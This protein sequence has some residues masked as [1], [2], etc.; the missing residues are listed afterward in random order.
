VN[1]LVKRIG[2]MAVAGV[3]TEDIR[4]I[5]KSLETLGRA[6][7]TI[8]HVVVIAALM[9]EAAAQAKVCDSNPCD[10][11]K[12]KIGDQREM[13]TAT[14]EYVLKIR[15]TVNETWHV[16][17]KPAVIKAGIPGL[18]VHDTRHSAISWWTNSGIPLAAVRDRARH[19][20]ISVTSRYIHVMPGDSN[21]FVAVIGEPA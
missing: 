10:P 5:V 11:V 4:R 17:W 15:R 2:G 20:N 6:D 1:H 9:F 13:M 3:Q 12:V 7:S 8:A 19:S 18:R 14:K 21:P 16:G